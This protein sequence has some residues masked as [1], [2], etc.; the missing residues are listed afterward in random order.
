[1]TVVC[2]T[3]NAVMIL[4]NELLHRLEV[5]ES[6]VILLEGTRALPPGMDAVLTRFS[7]KLAEMIPHGI[8][9][10]GNAP[11]SDDAFSRGVEAIAPERLEQFLPTT[12]HRPATLH[13]AARVLALDALTLKV[14]EEIA[15]ETV[16]G[17]PKYASMI[18]NRL[19][20]K[21]KTKSD[22]LMR[23]TLKVTGDGKMF[24]PANVGI[25]FINPD[26]PDGGGTG[27]TIAVCRKR[28]TVLIYTQHEWLH[29]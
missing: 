19:V 26:N 20:P 17:S 10:S 3:F 24:A 8:F 4:P 18:K 16:A 15:I 14:A 6:P 28:G 5:L 11:G 1:M 7:A 2:C 13:P 12:K 22:Y 9:R 23:D 27:H 25:F 21:L 29:W